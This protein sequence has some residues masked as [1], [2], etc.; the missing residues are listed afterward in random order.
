MPKI[1]VIMPVYNSEKYLSEAIDSILNQTYGDFEFIIIDD[2]STDSSQEIVRSY[3]DP[4]IRFYINEHN[5]GVAATLNR[6]LDLATAEYIARMDSDDISELCRFEKQVEFLDQHKSVGVVGSALRNFGEGISEQIVEFSTDVEQ[7]KV[8]M[9]YSCPLGHPTIMMRSCVLHENNL[10]Y[11]KSYEGFEDFALWWRI[12]EYWDIVS[13]KMPLLRYRKHAS[14]VTKNKSPEF[15][16]RFDAFHKERLSVFRCKVAPNQ[17]DQFIKYCDG[18]HSEFDIE[19]LKEFIELLKQLLNVNQNLH[20]FNQMVLRGAFGASGIKVLT[21]MQLNP[22]RKLK[23]LHYMRKSNVI[24]A[25]DEMKA[26]IH[27]LLE[28]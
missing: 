15:Y 27:I 6:G 7:A 1:S 17:L 19:N 5:M 20:I 26:A 2:G 9:I 8:D 11:Q 4:R 3:T 13:M 10:H 24:G 12:G 21:L 14:Q 28:R 23:L 16:K 18:R 25:I 22:V